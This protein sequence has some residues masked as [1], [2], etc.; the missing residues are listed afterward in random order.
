MGLQR[1]AW[2]FLGLHRSAEFVSSVFAFQ[3]CSTHN[4]PDG[5]CLD[6]CLMVLIP[7]IAGDSFSLFHLYTETYLNR[8]KHPGCCVLLAPFWAASP[9]FFLS[10]DP[11]RPPS[12]ETPFFVCRGHRWQTWC[13]PCLQCGDFSQQTL[14]RLE[15]IALGYFSWQNWQSWSSAQHMGGVQP[16]QCWQVCENSLCLIFAV[17]LDPNLS[18]TSSAGE[19]SC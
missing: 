12:L 16:P 2:M 4:F 10:S 8:Y 19:V 15:Q 14:G 3:I 13:L 9:V 18:V 17:L 6:R 5:Q 11:V 1:G 7:I